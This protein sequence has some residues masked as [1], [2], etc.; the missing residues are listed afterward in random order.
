MLEGKIKKLL[1][2]HHE[3]VDGWQLQD[4]TLVHFPPHIGKQLGEW[5]EVGDDVSLDGECHTNRNGDEVLFP[6]YIESQGWSL[7]FDQ[8]KP[9]DRKDPGDKRSPERRMQPVSNKDIMLELKK[10]RRLIEAWTE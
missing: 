9:H 1:Y 4:G 7:T 8:K 5:I 6:T 2:N 3:D 10:I